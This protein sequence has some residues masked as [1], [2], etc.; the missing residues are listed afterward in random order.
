MKKCIKHILV[1]AAALFVVGLIIPERYQ[2]P[3]GTTDSY[4]H[5]S[6]WWHPWTRGVNGS[7]HHGVYIFGKEWTEV[8]PPVGGVVL[9][10]GWFDDVAGNMIIVLGPKWKLHEYM[11]LNENFVSPGQIVGHDTVIGRQPEEFNWKKMFYLNPDE[12][13]RSK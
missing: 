4:S 6:F 5:Q 1:A 13:L 11:H 7:P 10:S 8:R 3:C 9:Y 2:M 12:Y